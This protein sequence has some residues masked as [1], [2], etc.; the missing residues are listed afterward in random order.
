[1]PLQECEPKLQCLIPLLI[2]PSHEW[3]SCEIGAVNTLIWHST[4]GRHN[5]CRLQEHPEPAISEVKGY[6]EALVEIC[7]GPDRPN[8]LRLETSE[9]GQLFGIERLSIWRKK[10]SSLGVHRAKQTGLIRDALHKGVV[11]EPKFGAVVVETTLCDVLAVE[12]LWLKLG[13]HFSEASPCAECDDTNFPTGSHHLRTMRQ[14][15]SLYLAGLSHLGL[16]H[17]AGSGIPD[18]VKGIRSQHRPRNRSG[19]ADRNGL[20][21]RS[22]NLD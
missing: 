19:V 16:E 21:F 14:S 2:V 12:V 9:H 15:E 13:E 6:P 20:P 5:D 10:K 7:S 17:G 11:Q 1:M 3:F 4:V 18:N 8:A 22:C